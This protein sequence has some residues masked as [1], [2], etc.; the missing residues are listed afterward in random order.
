[1]SHKYLQMPSRP[2]S[3]LII[4]FRLIELE[5]GPNMNFISG[6]NGSGKSAV[7]SAIILGKYLP[8]SR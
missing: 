3:I 8:V 7:L 5:F 4:V 2:F 6:R 1:M